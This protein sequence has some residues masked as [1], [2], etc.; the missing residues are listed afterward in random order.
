MQEKKKENN[1]ERGKR[2]ERLAS[3][4]QPMVAGAGCHQSQQ[5]GIEK[6]REEREK[7]RRVRW[8]RKR[9]AEKREKE[10]SVGEERCWPALA[11]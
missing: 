8:R 7:E 3:L 11:G 2:G 10:I 5:R 1:R 6:V 4:D 9:E